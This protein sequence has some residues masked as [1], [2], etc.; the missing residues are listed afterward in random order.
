[1]VAP[2]PTRSHSA[3][4][5]V[6]RR[7]QRWLLFVHQLP[8]SPSNLRVRTWRRLQQIGALPLKQ[9]LYVLPD[10][11]SAREDFEWLKSE[12]E[13]AGGQASVFTAD[14]VDAW[15]N[16]GLVDEFRRTRET[17]YM[18]LAREGEQL[19]KGRARARKHAMP[20][21]TLQQLK[22]RFAAIDQIDF[23]G[24]AGRDRV[25]TLLHQLDERALGRTKPAREKGAQTSGYQRRLWVTRPRPGVDR[26]ASAWLI[27]RFIDQKAQFGFVPDRDAAPPDAVPFDMF[28]VEFTHRGDLCTFEMLCDTFHLRTAGL[29]ALAAVVHDL[30]FKDA[31]FGAAEAPAVGLIIEGLRLSY[32]DDHALLNEGI[33]LFEALHRAFEQARRLG[34]PRPVSSRRTQQ[35]PRRG[36]SR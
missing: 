32:A 12:I 6:E 17:A 5:R 31:R 25:V 22:E 8:A 10:T 13:A 18:Q 15:S 23:F 16:D 11:P 9:A 2:R 35:R 26:M 33:V 24:G 30:D 4:P 14:A 21:R 20:L 28:G 27:R 19:L 7:S 36:R 29:E 3:T 1:M 34:G